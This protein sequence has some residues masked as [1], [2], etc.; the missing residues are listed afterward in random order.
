MKKLF[1]FAIT[2]A[3]MLASASAET[4]RGQ[5]ADN[6]QKRIAQ[7]V[8]NGSLTP[9]ETAR[10]ERR[11]GALARDARKM[12]QSGGGLTAGE[13][14]K[15]EVRQDRISRDIHREKHDGQNRR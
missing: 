7:G 14:A 15:I 10:L 11:E 8:R 2:S 6:Q 13:K 1:V 4:R 3:L 5:R 12:R 9:G